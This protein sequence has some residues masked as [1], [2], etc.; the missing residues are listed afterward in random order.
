MTAQ[1]PAVIDDAQPHSHHWGWDSAN[2]GQNA[3]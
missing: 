2:G 3:K 1:P